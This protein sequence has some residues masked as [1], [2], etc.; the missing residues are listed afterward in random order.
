MMGRGVYTT[1]GM[2]K[3][4][5]GLDMMHGY[6]QSLNLTQCGNTLALDAAVIAV[7][8]SEELLA[9]MADVSTSTRG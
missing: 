8:K 5:F 1:E 6:V 4:G 7:P 3:L 2:K 9:L